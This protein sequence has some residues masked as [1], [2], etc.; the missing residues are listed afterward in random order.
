MNATAKDL[1]FKT[2]VLL[3]TVARGE[4]VSISYRGRLV[5]RMVPAQAQPRRKAE[6]LESF[7]LWKDRADMA[8]PAAWV[9]EQRKARR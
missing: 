5:A 1:R 9:R 3:D 4:T 7:G 2:K 6:E 8:D